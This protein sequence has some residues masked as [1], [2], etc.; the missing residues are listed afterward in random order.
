MLMVYVLC[1]IGYWSGGLSLIALVFPIVFYFFFLIAIDSK[2]GHKIK[3]I[4][5]QNKN[6]K[7]FLQE[8]EE[9]LGKSY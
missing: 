2:S 6:S 5:R 9:F 8:R 3:A 4:A 1:I 7:H